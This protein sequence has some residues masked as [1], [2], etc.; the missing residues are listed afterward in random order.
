MFGEPCKSF[1]SVASNLLLF[2]IIFQTKVKGRWLF[3]TILLGNGSLFYTFSPD[4][5]VCD[6]ATSSPAIFR[7][8]DYYSD[9]PSKLNLFKFNPERISLLF[10]FQYQ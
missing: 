9:I 8:L 2:L 1:Q 3:T 4:K 5:G 7:C 6:F 10:E